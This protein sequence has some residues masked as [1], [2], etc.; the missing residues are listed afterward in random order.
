MS[1]TIT[2]PYT[3]H[4]REVIQSLEV[5]LPVPDV[6]MDQDEEWIVANTKRGWRKIRLHDYDEVYAVPGLYEKWVYDLFKCRSP[7]KVA[8]LLLPAIEEAGQAPASVTVLDLGRW[9]RICR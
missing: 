3:S 8:G 6:D 9:K 1:Q 7:Q 4:L 2:E 5:A